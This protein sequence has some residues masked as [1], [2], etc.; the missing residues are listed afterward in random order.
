[1][2]D[3]TCGSSRWLGPLSYVGELLLL[4]VMK[5]GLNNTVNKIHIII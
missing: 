2:R 4:Q 1:M 3:T 5:T